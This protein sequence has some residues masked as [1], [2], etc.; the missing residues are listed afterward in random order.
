MSSAQLALLRS[1]FPYPERKIFRRRAILKAGDAC[2]A[3]ART[4]D[5]SSQ[6]LNLMIDRPLPVGERVTLAFNITIDQKTRQ[7]EFKGRVGY[8]VLTGTEGYRMRFDVDVR[9]DADCH[10]RLAGLMERLV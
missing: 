9:A 3:D 5:L 2:Y 6:D 1:R 4:L 7:L 10:A 8:C